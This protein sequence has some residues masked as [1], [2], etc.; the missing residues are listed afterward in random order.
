[1]AMWAAETESLELEN[2][3]VQYMYV[4]KELASNKGANKD[5]QLTCPLTS[6]E[7]LG[8]ARMRTHG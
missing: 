1:M 7:L 3:L 5:P 2:S 8:H 6:T 4:N